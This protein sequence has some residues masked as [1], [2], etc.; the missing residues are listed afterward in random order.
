M[1]SGITPP[2]YA[3]AT[4]FVRSSERE[5]V[6]FGQDKDPLRAR[7]VLGLDS[8][9]PQLGL[10]ELIGRRAQLREILR[11]LREP[12]Q[13]VAGVVVTGIGG[14]G[15]S[16]LAG[17]AMQ[18]MIESGYAV[19]A[20]VGKW[21]LG[22]VTHAVGTALIGARAKPGPAAQALV[23]PELPDEVRWALS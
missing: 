5:L 9:V 13:G 21:E 8:P 20:V 7:S 12:P 6:D 15:K 10:D 11:T 14:I 22:A 17:R 16:A 19:A 4:L 2:E 18:R 23:N 1:G 3:T